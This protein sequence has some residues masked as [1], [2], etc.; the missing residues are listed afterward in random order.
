MYLLP[1]RSQIVKSK[2][3]IA[4]ETKL[5]LL[6]PSFENNVSVTK[7]YLIFK[8]IVLSVI[9]ISVLSILIDKMNLVKVRRKKRMAC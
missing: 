2:P 9:K 6:A 1:A 5:L 4:E 8:V 7:K 3:S